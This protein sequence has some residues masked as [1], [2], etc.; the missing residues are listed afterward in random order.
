MIDRQE[1]FYFA[2]LTPAEYQD[3]TEQPRLPFMDHGDASAEDIT[4]MEQIARAFM[5]AARS[6]R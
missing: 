6:R 2:R 1:R 4:D 5:K 3:D